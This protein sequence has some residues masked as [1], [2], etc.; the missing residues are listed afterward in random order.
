MGA[1]PLHPHLRLFLD[2]SGALADAAAAGW[3]RTHTALQ[4]RRRGS[5]TTRRPGADSPMWN[6]LATELRREL[7]PAG[8][9]ARLAR[10]LGIPRQRLNDFLKLKSRLPDAELTLRLLHWLTETRSGR[11]PA[12]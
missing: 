8:A 7:K 12:V 9:K 1:I 11:D 10:Y 4:P 5:F 2:F 6:V 3:R